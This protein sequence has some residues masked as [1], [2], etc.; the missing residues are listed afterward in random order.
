[1]TTTLTSRSQTNKYCTAIAVT[2]IPATVKLTKDIKSDVFT[3]GSHLERGI[4]D[5]NKRQELA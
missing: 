3:I 4:N 1:M 2:K 5:N